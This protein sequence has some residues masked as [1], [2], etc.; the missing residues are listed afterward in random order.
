MRVCSRRLGNSYSRAFTLIE[1]IISG[2]LMALVLT[3]AYVCLSAAYSTQRMIDS[4]SDA[5]QNGRVALTLIAADLR[6]TV[7]VSKEAEF[8]G[9][10]RLLDQDN[11]D[12]LDFG[13]RNYVPRHSREPDYCEVSYFVE[14]DPATTT[15]TLFR[16]RDSTP[17]PEPFSG[18]TR[19]EIARGLLGLRF[20]YYDG[21]DWYDNWGDPSGKKKLSTFPEPNVSGLP[22]A[23]RVTITLRP[24]FEHRNHSR[25]QQD[26]DEPPMTM[27]T[28]ARVN[29][30]S[31]FYQSSGGGSSSDIAP[32]EPSKT[33]TGP[34][35]NLP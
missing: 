11:A 31:F 8:V 16:R 7:P 35:G 9:M 26:S 15:L 3:S 29:L 1:M 10:H 24:G 4:R 18:G 28:V 13:T 27:Q 25:R 19:E 32:G 33:S 34:V 14:R 30:S 12:N 6:S 23:V 5:A 17:D 22:E 21:L 2:A 20:E